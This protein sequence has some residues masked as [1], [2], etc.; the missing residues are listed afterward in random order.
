MQKSTI[1]INKTGLADAR[2]RPKYRFK[3][4]P[5]LS[6]LDENPS[7]HV[8]VIEAVRPLNLERAYE[9]IKKGYRFDVYIK[10]GYPSFYHIVFQKYFKLVDKIN[11]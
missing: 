5:K 8:I 6:S 7:K 11:N 4:I 2:K 3:S 1:T 9:L 10:K